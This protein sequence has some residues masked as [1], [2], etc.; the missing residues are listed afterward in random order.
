MYREGEGWA[1]LQ[2][3]HT[4]RARHAKTYGG[5]LRV[6]QYLP[7]RAGV[8]QS[9]NGLAWEETRRSRPWSDSDIDCLLASL[10]VLIRSHEPCDLPDGRVRATFDGAAYWDLLAAIDREPQRKR[11]A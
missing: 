2:P 5:V 11:A 3:K 7:N 4:R 9:D 6:G 8:T 10:Q 1:L